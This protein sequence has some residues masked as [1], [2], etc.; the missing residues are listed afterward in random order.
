M[1]TCVDVFLIL[2]LVVVKHSHVSK[3]LLKTLVIIFGVSFCKVINK[4]LYFFTISF[5]LFE[6]YSFVAKVRVF[7]LHGV[8]QKFIQYQLFLY[9]FY[10][11]ALTKIY[12]A[13]DFF[14]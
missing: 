7:C 3:C 10:L 4:Y 1:Q 8:S 9:F 11:E 5:F 6:K 2:F 12:N 14:V 13:V